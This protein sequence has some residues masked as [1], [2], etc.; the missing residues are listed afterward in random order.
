MHSLAPS[1][2]FFD[3]PK[4]TCYW[5]MSFTVPL[6]K[7]WKGVS[8]VNITWNSIFGFLFLTD[9]IIKRLRINERLCV[10]LDGVKLGVDRCCEDLLEEKLIGS[11]WETASVNYLVKMATTKATLAV[12]LPL[13]DFHA[14][15]R[16]KNVKNYA[17]NN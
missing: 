1:E 4:N 8:G 9:V 10:F 5:A 2:V 14:S 12:C 15:K 11:H 3:D 6:T 17:V 13:V 7:L 16:V